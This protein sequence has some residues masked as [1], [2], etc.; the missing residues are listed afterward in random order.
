MAKEFLFSQ[1]IRQIESLEDNDED[2]YLIGG[3]PMFRVLCIDYGVLKDADLNDL[4]PIPRHFVDRLPAQSIECKISDICP[5][6]GSGWSDEAGDLI[7]KLTD[8]GDAVF[9]ATDVK[10]IVQVL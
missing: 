6:D 4:M 3:S 9:R 10:K 8:D 2:P 1:V 5:I 7:Y